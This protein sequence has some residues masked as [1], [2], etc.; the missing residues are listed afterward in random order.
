MIAAVLEREPAPLEVSPPLERV[1]RRALAKDPEQRFQSARDLKT[2][3]EWA[4]EPQA[5]SPPNTTR[6][7]QWIAGA[8]LVVGAALAGAWGMTHLRQPMAADRA[9]RLE[10]TPPE[11]D[12]FVPWATPLAGAPYRPTAGWWHSRQPS[13]EKRG[14]GCGPST[15]QPYTSC[16]EPRVLGARFGRPTANPSASRRQAS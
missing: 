15:I 5:A 8:A 3:L 7:W 2:A 14:C 4:M 10:I 13:M 11:G 16:R 1:V 12:R 9:L 6:R